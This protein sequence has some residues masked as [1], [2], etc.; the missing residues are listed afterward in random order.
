MLKPLFLL[1]CLPLALGTSL[2]SKT[3]LEYTL[4]VDPADLSGVAVELR[5]RNA[6]ASLQL[7]AHAHPEY[8]DRYWR[9]VED[10]TAFDSNGLAVVVTRQD[11]VLWRV[12]NTGDVTVRYRVRFPQEGPPRAAWRP[13]L[14]PN[15]GLV[16]G[17]HSFLYVVGAES[18]PATVTLELPVGWRADTAP[19]TYRLTQDPTPRAF[20]YGVPVTSWKRF[21]HP[22]RVPLTRTSKCKCGPKQ[23]PV[24]P[25]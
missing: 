21:T 16:G 5:V 1:V 11:S 12:A 4:R 20:D 3:S 19:G 23:W 24:Q 14:A 10:V 13:F 25:T 7:A 15:G 6:P 18:A 22:P 8:D 17:P 9:H 2:G